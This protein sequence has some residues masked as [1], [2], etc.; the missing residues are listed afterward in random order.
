MVNL[1]VLNWND[2]KFFVVVA[3]SGSLTR[4]ASILRLNHSTAFRRINSLEEALDTKLFIRLPDGYKLSEIGLEV[5]R[6]AEEMSAI[7]TYIKSVLDPQNEDM[8]GQLS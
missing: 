4:A 3:Q 2:L 1:D 6:Y 7:V 8:K 5:L